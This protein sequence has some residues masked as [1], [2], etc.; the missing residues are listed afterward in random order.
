MRLII[1]GL[2]AGLVGV[3]TYSTQSVAAEIQEGVAMANR[4][5]EKVSS[6]SRTRHRHTA[7]GPGQKA[8]VQTDAP[9]I[10]MAC[11]SV[12]FPRHPLCPERGFDLNRMGWFW[13]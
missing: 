13:W 8:Y 4:V 10:P 5:S 1:W 6:L 7:V 9:I 2:A 12:M 11:E 3:S